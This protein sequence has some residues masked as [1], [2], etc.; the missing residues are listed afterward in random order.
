MV[1]V[2]KG[3]MCSHGGSGGACTLCE[4]LGGKGTTRAMPV[5]LRSIHVSRQHDAYYAS[6]H[7]LLHVS[8]EVCEAVLKLGS[9]ILP[10]PASLP[11]GEKERSTT[12]KGSRILTDH[13]HHAKV[14]QVYIYIYIYLYFQ[15]GGGSPSYYAA[16]TAN[17][18]TAAN[19]I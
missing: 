10:S 1:Q 17:T 19:D 15:R 14:I 9:Y 4:G 7:I 5:L 18:S 13:H 3:R 8:R 12:M 11:L 6:T 16:A 2:R